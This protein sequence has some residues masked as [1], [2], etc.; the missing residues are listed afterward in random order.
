MASRKAS[1]PIWGWPAIS[2]DYD[3]VGGVNVVSRI[4]PAQ[5][6]TTRVSQSAKSD[7]Q[8]QK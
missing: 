6:E 2:F 4:A 3:E 5:E 8:A 7:D 1:W